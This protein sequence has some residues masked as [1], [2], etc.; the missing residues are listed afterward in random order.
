M[1]PII[2]AFEG[3][4]YSGKTTIAKKVAELFNLET[5]VK[6][7]YI[8]LPGFSHLGSIL[9]NEIKQKNY[10]YL[11]SL[12]LA[13]TAHAA[14]YEELLTHTDTQVFILDRFIQS[15]VVYQ[16]MLEKA[17]II[18]N[19][20]LST[21]LN[22]L[23]QF[24]EQY[25]GLYFTIYLRTDIQTILKRQAETNRG[26]NS[27]DKFDNLSKESFSNLVSNYNI[28]FAYDPYKICTNSIIFSEKPEQTIEDNSRS[29]FKLLSAQI[30]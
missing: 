27:Q 26:N 14:A 16:G 6:A 13:L 30:L 4:D 12:G 8:Q 15:I 9:R 10:G 2:I 17:A 7:E 3:P 20:L 22:S 24:L 1:K 19:T 29:L 28:C 21:I 11:T 25:F 18:D 23:K 5:K